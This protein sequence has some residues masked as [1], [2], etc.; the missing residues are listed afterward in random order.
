MSGW[1]WVCLCGRKGVSMGSKAKAEGA[2]ERH[3]LKAAKGCETS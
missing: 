3:S 1:R 2:T